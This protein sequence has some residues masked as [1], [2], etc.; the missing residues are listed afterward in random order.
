MTD[1]ASMLRVD[2]IVFSEWIMVVYLTQMHSKRQ[3]GE[4]FTKTR[5]FNAELQGR[6]KQGLSV[7]SK[8]VTSWDINVIDGS[9]WCAACQHS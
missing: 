8:S 4:R 5:L 2:L 1:L 7:S 9:A 3:I 6:G